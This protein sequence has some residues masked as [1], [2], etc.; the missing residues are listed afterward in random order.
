MQDFKDLFVEET[1]YLEA[2][3]KYTVEGIM[4]EMLPSSNSSR[5]ITFNF[6]QRECHVLPYPPRYWFNP[7]LKNLRSLM[8]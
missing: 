8:Y 3:E 2:E 4:L 7:A 1:K 5:A 6:E